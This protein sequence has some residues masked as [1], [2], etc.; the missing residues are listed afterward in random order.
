MPSRSDYITLARDFRRELDEENLAFKSYQRL[1]VT[2][3]LRQ[4]SK[5]E[6]TR[7]GSNVAE[8]LGDAFRDQGLRVFPLLK[9]TGTDDLVRVWRSG[10]LA[11]Q[12][13]DLLLTPGESSDRA[14][15]GLTQ[16]LRGR[17]WH[18]T[19]PESELDA[20]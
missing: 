17:Q 14:L 7:M 11:T 18:W 16:I 3:R 13:L 20:K 8:A 6:N 9:G 5:E 4:I 15:A 2:N 10:T 1:D 12:I 19:D